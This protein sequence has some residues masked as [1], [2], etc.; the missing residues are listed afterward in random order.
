MTWI[1]NDIGKWTIFDDI[2]LKNTKF[3]FFF[4]ADCIYIWN[5][6]WEFL[7]RRKFKSFLT[8]SFQVANQMAK[9]REQV[10]ELLIYGWIREI[11]DKVPDEIMDECYRWYDS[12]CYFMDGSHDVIINAERDTIKCSGLLD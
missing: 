9:T 12:R 5:I 10:D 2:G 6:C 3:L 11:N 4:F 7:L 8:S 1:Q